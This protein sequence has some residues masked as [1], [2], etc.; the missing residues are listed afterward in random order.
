[1]A[2]IRCA[3]CKGTHTS[4][5]Q[6]REC[7][8]VGAVATVRPE[9]QVAAVTRLREAAVRDA[10]SRT[11]SDAP[12]VS[13]WGDG[14][15]ESRGAYLRPEE[16]ARVHVTRPKAQPLLGTPR[17]HGESGVPAGRY[18][19]EVDGTLKFYV[20]DRPTEGRWAGYTF[21]KVQASDDTFPVRSR[22]ARTA[23]LAQ[24]S[25]DVEGAMLR[26]GREIGR[27]GH[28]GRT[29]TNEESRARGIGPVCA[30]K[31]GF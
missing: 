19:I 22:E 6:V 14:E 4:V 25:D 13:V 8:G 17:S 26:Y 23:I 7:A 20:V 12:N 16:E 5:A 2:S 15:P 11:Y 9:A 1:M 27:C 10:I 31:M 3:H 24:I 30:G 21:V 18:A 29:L 28:C